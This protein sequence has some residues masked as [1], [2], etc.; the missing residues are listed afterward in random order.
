[1]SL[2]CIGIAA[3][4]VA[5]G[6]L[7]FSRIHITRKASNEAIEDKEVAEAFNRIS[8]WPQFRLLRKMVVQQLIGYDPSGTIIDIGCGSGYL[9]ETI[10][11]QLRRV[12]LIGI[13][14]AKEM[15]DTAKRRT[16][17]ASLEDGPS[18]LEGNVANLPLGDDSVDFVVSSLSLHHWQNPLL[19]LREIYR[20]LKP[21]GQMLLFDLGRDSR[22][23]FYCLLRLAQAFVVPSAL[24]KA[25]EPLGSLIASYSIE[26]LAGIL[27]KTQFE[28]S[29]IS[30]R[31]GWAYVWAKKE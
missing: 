23:W 1:M 18:F 26:E 28:E 31:T 6:Y 10:S 11:R 12:R 21:G 14:Y 15:I 20:I 8:Q 27:E 16:E 4:I 25:N 30:S 5:I 3:I 17:V 24:R 7:S 29:K 19:A 22:R 2:L 13:D 9:L